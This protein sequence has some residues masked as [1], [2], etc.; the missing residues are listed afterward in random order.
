MNILLTGGTGYIGS[1]TAVVL[2]N[3]FNL[4]P[5]KGQS[6]HEMINSFHAVSGKPVPWEMGPRRAGDVSASY[7]SAEKAAATLR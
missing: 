3:A 1:H 5:G 6:V 2:T 4:G 7:A